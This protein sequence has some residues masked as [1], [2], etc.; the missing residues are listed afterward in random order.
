MSGQKKKE[1]ATFCS[2][3]EIYLLKG[4]DLLMLTDVFSHISCR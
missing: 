1:R 2:E 3:K 4:A